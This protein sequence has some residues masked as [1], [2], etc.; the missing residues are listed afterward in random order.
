MGYL[1]TLGE[2]LE[3]AREA[4]WAPKPFPLIQTRIKPVWNRKFCK[5]QLCKF[6]N[7]NPIF[8][9]RIDWKP[10]NPTQ[11][12]PSP[13]LT[14]SLTFRILEI[15]LPNVPIFGG[16]KVSS[17]AVWALDRPVPGGAHQRTYFFAAFPYP[18][19]AEKFSERSNPLAHGSPSLSNSHSRRPKFS[20][21]AR[22]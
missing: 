2:I 20:Y 10:S 15:T 13:S 4:W 8:A 7:R 17:T 21:S 3:P 12:G 5:L 22:S 18:A 11:G 19:I 1:P 14:P 9:F 16:H 6:K